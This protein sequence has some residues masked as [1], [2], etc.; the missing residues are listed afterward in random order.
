MKKKKSV[1]VNRHSVRYW[2]I[3]TFRAIFWYEIGRTLVCYVIYAGVAL[4]KAGV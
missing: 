4:C 2:A 3:E 1:M